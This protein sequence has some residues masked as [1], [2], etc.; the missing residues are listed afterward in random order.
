MIARIG[1]NT[2]M[3]SPFS[4]WG[5]VTRSINGKHSAKINS[6]SSVPVRRN[7][8]L[9]ALATGGLLAVLVSVAGASPAAASSGDCDAGDVDS[10]P[11]VYRVVK[12]GSSFTAY[13]RTVELLNGSAFN[14]SFARISTGYERGD[15][16]WID[17]SLRG[18]PRSLPAHPTQQQVKDNGSWKQC[19]P[20]KRKVS[21]L[22]MNWNTTTQNHFATRA[23][24]RP[25]DGRSS[26]CGY[27]YIDRG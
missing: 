27:W 6:G 9:A 26:V 3:I 4:F 11:D 17:R 20:F 8:R 22:V 15:L 5:P 25:R 13:G 10:R 24:M 12:S 16:V 2:M 19:G 21:N 18:M 7:Q 14:F 23:C 1:K